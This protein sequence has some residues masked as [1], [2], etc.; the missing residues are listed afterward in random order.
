MS[1]GREID[2]D[3]LADQRRLSPFAAFLAIGLAAMGALS[4]C[5]PSVATHGHSLDQEQ[6]AKVREGQTSRQEVLQLMGSP[7]A[8]S[9]FDDDAWYYVTQRTEKLSFYQE[10]VVEQEVVT[11]S[12]DDRDRVA[13]VERHGLDQVASIDPVNRVTPTAGASPSIFEQLISNI[14]RFGDAGNTYDPDN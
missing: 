10:D 6:L 8:L 13:S 9:T 4:A 5:S 1:F 14:G 11:I 3:R 2:N 7:S 12:F